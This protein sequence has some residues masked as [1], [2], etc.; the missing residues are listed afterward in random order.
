[1]KTNIKNKKCE[2]FSRAWAKMIKMFLTKH[3]S[4]DIG[5]Y[6]AYAF[7]IFFFVVLFLGYG[8]VSECP[9]SELISC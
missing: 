1:M 7:I 8:S 9:D 4:D 5:L 3:N 2:T 6:I